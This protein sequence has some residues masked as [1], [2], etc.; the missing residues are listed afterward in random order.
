VCG[1]AGI[2]DPT[3]STTAEQLAELAD[4]MSAQVAHRGPEED[5][6]WVDAEVGVALGHRRLRIV[7]LSPTGSQPMVSASGRTVVVFNG[8]VYDH[9]RLRA[10]LEASGH[11]FRGTSD[12]EVLVEGVEAWGVRGFLERSNAMLAVAVWDRAERRLTLAR[13]RLGERPLYYGVVGGCFAFGSELRTLRMLPGFDATL[14][15]GSLAAYVRYGFVPHPRTVFAG[16]R[17]LPPGSLLTV[18]PGL[19]LDAEP[20]R[21]WD[22]AEVVRRGVGRRLLPPPDD[23]A[24][25][26]HELLLDAVDLRRE[27]D[28]PLGAFLSG[29]IDSTAIVALMQAKADRPVRTFTVRMPTLAYDESEAAAA[30]ARHLGTE[31]TVVDLSVDEA[32][33]AVPR[34]AATWD[35]PFADPSQLPTLLVAEAARR[36]V[37]VSL[38]GDGGDEVF[39]GYNRHVLGPR[40]WS[41]TRRLPAGVR[42]RVA[43]G[44][45]AVRP[46]TWDRLGRI[47]PVRNPG[48]KAGKLA[49]MLAADGDDAAWTVLA[50]VWDDPRA[51]LGDVEEAI[52]AAVARTDLPFVG[53]LE[54]ML[55]LDAAVVLPDNMLVKVDRAAM[56]CALE[57]R[58][59]FLDHRVVEHAWRLPAELKVH[60]GRGKRILREVLD[61]YVPRD[62]VDRPKMGFDP[63][64]GEWLRGPLRDW[65]EELLSP[66]RLADGGV[67]AVEPVRACWDEHLSGRRRWDYR[68]WTVLSFGA[69]LEADGR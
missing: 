44:I 38:S 8:E 3:T 23:A 31:H 48:D 5:A 30:V 25:E 60:D 51:L 21:W 29:G 19:P 56:S 33:A 66:A 26:L 49:R 69:W 61:R 15:R 62:L 24:D 50:S 28:V 10:E 43:S 4:R 2:V 35:E 59:P 46:D 39:G 12:T 40:M 13:D 6:V 9:R 58:V 27:A 68:L 42:R 67:F 52:P 63:P 57:V 1:I 45:G 7:D 20:E 64:L 16:V 11:R 32:L 36:H 22:L 17:Q 41:A 47:S 54:R 18:G 37:T 53:P 55:Y 14:D 34:L 65:A